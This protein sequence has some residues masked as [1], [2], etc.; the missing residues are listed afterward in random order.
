MFLKKL[1]ISTFG[2]IIR[3]IPFHK[4]INLIVDES[5]DQVTGNNVGKTTVLK[6]IDFCLGADAKQIYIDPET[7]RDEYALVK[8]FLV[9]YEVI[10]TLT[11]SE[12]IDSNAGQD[13]VIERNFLSYKK[14]IRRINNEDLTKEEF[15]VK[16]N[17]LE[18]LMINWLQSIIAIVDTEQRFYSKVYVK[19]DDLSQYS[20]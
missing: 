12:N 13:I 6:L 15:E 1:K 17:N 10:V 14:A 18:E 2:N 7:K 11:L 16:G 8:D 9:D 4:G 5:K 19:E 3:D 20:V